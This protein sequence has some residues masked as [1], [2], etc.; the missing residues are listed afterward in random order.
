MTRIPASDLNAMLVR[1]ER[2]GGFTYNPRTQRFVTGAGYVVANP[3]SGE[4]PTS[5]KFCDVS[6]IAPLT[7]S[8][9][10][11][12]ALMFSRLLAVPS[13]YLGAWKDGATVYVEVSQVFRSRGEALRVAADRGERAIYDLRNRR[14]IPV[15]RVA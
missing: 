4:V 5:A 12:V 15:A 13:Y 1:I 10:A 8:D 2:D 11:R 7:D 9:L 14:D 3:P 6:R